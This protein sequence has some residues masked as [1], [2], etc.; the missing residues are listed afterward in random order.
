MME[1]AYV[2]SSLE[3][4]RGRQPRA[5]Q[6]ALVAFFWSPVGVSIIGSTALATIEL[7]VALAFTVPN[8][9][10]ERL[11]GLLV[12]AAFGKV[13]VTH[14]LVWTPLLVAGGT[15]RWLLLRNR[16]IRPG[17][18]LLGAVFA[19]LAVVSPR[20]LRFVYL[21]M[22]LAVFPIGLVVSELILLSVFVL[23]FTPLALVFRWIGRDALDRTI[24]RD[25]ESYWRPKQSPSDPRS[26]FRQS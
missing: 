22:T 19:A 5:Q 14:V 17:G 26:Y 12:L 6:T 13:L 9:F 21:G 2:E 20:A 24:D 3:D 15:V 8:S 11:P 16:L 25:A 10:G 1:H 18:P 4:R 23:V 7:M